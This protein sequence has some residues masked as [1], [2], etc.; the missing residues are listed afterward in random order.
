MQLKAIY[1][2]KNGVLA[3][4]NN[5]QFAFFSNEGEFRR[6]ATMAEVDHLSKV[7]TMA[8][9]LREFFRQEDMPIWVPLWSATHYD[10]S[11]MIG[12]M[13]SNGGAYGYFTRREYFAGLVN[14][15]QVCRMLETC[16]NTSDFYTD[17]AGKFCQQ[18]ECEEVIL[19]NVMPE[20]NGITGEYRQKS[21]F[22]RAESDAGTSYAVLEQHSTEVDFAAAIR[23]GG[24]KITSG[25]EWDGR[26]AETPSKKVVSIVGFQEAKRRLVILSEFGCNKR[27]TRRAKP[28]QTRR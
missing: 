25:Y 9:V 5:N 27:I 7:A 14:G 20:K 3:P 6:Q 12:S 19:S 26:P 24:S 22:F 13:S 10:N 15:K 2:T 1:L 28:A 23:D 11:G 16:G 17:D 8:Y 18:Y 21:L 4:A